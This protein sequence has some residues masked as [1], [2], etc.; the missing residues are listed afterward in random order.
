MRKKRYIGFWAGQQEEIKEFP[1]A[2]DFVDKK[3]HRENKQ[4]VTLI[5]KYLSLEEHEKIH[6]TKGWST[7]RFCKQA[8]PG[9]CEITD[10]EYI[11]PSGYIHYIEKHKVVP[12]PRFV[13][14]VLRFFKEGS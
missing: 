8:T 10:G 6:P 5:L 13:R 1:R 7:C 3:F 9:S 11:W 12:P 14:K 2:G 4:G